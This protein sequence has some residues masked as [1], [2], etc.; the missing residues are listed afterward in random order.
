MNTANVTML[1]PEGFGEL[2]ENEADTIR[3]LEYT[4]LSRRGLSELMDT[5]WELTFGLIP[6][7]RIGVAFVDDDHQR[8][9]AHYSRAVYS[10]VLLDGGFSSG[11]AGSTLK[12]M[13]ESGKGRIIS[14]LADYYST[15]PDSVSTQL[16]LEEGVRSSL[17][18]PLKV[19][20]RQV[21]FIF[22]SS[23][24]PDAFCLRHGALLFALIKVMSSGIEKAWLLRKLEQANSDYATLMGFV[25]HELKSPLSTMMMLGYT[26][27]EGYLGTVDPLAEDTIQKM[28]RI[29]GYMVNMISNYLGLSSLE[30]GELKYAPRDDVNFKSEVLDF[31]IDTIEARIKERL[32]TVN[33]TVEGSMPLLFADID[34]LRIV[35]INLLDNAVKYGL[36]NSIVQVNY[37]A[38]SGNF[39]FRV[40]NQGVGFTSEQSKKL[41]RRFSRLRQKGL[42]DRKGSGLGLFLSWWIIQKHQ[43]KIKATSKP[44]EWAEFEFEIPLNHC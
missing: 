38:H 31:A 16:L 41:F 37:S 43:G 40:R 21:G 5:I 39:I 34:L 6:H 28:L 7:D 12:L 4:I 30:A 26:Y 23:R 9:V 14:D 29:S 11:L 27:V 44:G 42:E 2:N 15:H 36:K 8:L 35:V 17:T 19:D 20:D 25:S 3:S 33:I 22:F 24:M 18:L 13:L 1:L 10:P 32:T